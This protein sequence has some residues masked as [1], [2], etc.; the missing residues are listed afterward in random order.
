[1]QQE[2]HIRRQ[3][4]LS[5]RKAATRWQ[6]P[7]RNKIRIR[8]KAYDTS[9][10]ESAAKEIVET[11]ARHRRDRLGSRAAADR[12]ERLLRDPLAVPR[13]RTLVSTS[14]SAPTSG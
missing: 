7:H 9:A 8:L 13:T 10:I 4:E 11:A 5:K 12:E 6:L 2:A 14:R 3:T 1:M